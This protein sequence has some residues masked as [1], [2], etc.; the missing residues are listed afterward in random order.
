MPLSVHDILEVLSD[1][2][3]TVLAGARGLTTRFVQTCVVIDVPD[4]HLWVHGGELLITAG[5]LF[6]KNPLNLLPLI[7]GSALAGGAALG[8][9]VGRFLGDLPKQVIELAD[10][11]DFPL[12]D[13]PPQVNHGD[14]ITHVL[15]AIVN[16]RFRILSQSSTI[17]D[18]FLEQVVR[19]NP[20]E[21]ILD[22][23]ESYTNCP[24]QLIQDGVDLPNNSKGMKEVDFENDL[25]S[26]IDSLTLAGRHV[27]SLRFLV[28]REPSDEMAKVA[29][30]NAK[31]ALMILI[32]QNFALR[33]AERRHSEGILQDLLFRRGLPGQDQLALVKMIG[34]V[35]EGYAL[36][37]LIKISEHSLLNTKKNLDVQQICRSCAYKVMARIKNTLVTELA[38]T[39]VF[40]LPVF[41]SSN[42]AAKLFQIIDSIR[43]E[44]EKEYDVQLIASLGSVKQNISKVSESYVEARETLD[45]VERMQKFKK[46][47]SWDDIDLERILVLIQGTDAGH[48]LVQK[49]LGPLILEDKKHESRVSGLVRTLDVY[50]DKNWSMKEAAIELSI[51]Y[52]TLK[53]R[54]QKIMNLI[55]L[56]LQNRQA[57]IEISIALS[58]YNIDNES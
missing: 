4:A 17:Q 3:I 2:K 8:I 52:N 40:I 50:A 37:A 58:L 16:Q 55:D 32:Q 25:S 54:L 15:A 48:K 34:W 11:L 36:A 44:V 18:Y 19:G 22:G 9:K 20:L 35:H 14:L 42:T 12:L 39:A 53:Y 13:I 28:G 31:T 7:E 30:A 5:Y 43:M 47:A 57:R 23:F 56:D 46:I 33:D 6:S 26:R 29:L 38:G 49:C 10:K 45:V 41:E 1:Y 27:G 21:N 24:V 51:H